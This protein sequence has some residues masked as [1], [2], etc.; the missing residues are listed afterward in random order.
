[1]FK[2]LLSV[3]LESRCLLCDRAT[4]ETICLYCQRKLSSY[5]GDN[6]S[7]QGDLPIFAWGK[8]DGSLK[9]AIAKLKYE[10]QSEIGKILGKWLGQTWKQNN[11]ISGRNISVIPIPLHPE[12]LKTRGY[13][14]AKI[15]AEGFCQETGYY[16]QPNS[17]T[18]VRNTKAMFE[19]NALERISNLNNAFALGDRLPPYPVL[20]L[21]DIYTSGT[22]VRE[23]T[24]VLRQHRVKVIGVVIVAQ[25]SKLET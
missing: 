1:M 7:W 18:R 11:L 22:T 8:Y 2:Q 25:T 9:R 12:K 24:R 20:I 17:L 5:Q 10:G 14:Q 21:D 6:H 4:G 13:N 19:L 23:A 3:F 16:L 15:I